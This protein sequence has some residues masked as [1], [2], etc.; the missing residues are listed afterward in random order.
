MPY[1]ASSVMYCT[2]PPPLSATAAA[3]LA[4]CRHRRP[5]PL[6]NGATKA[7]ANLVTV[8]AKEADAGAAR[9]RSKG[10]QEDEQEHGEQQEQQG[11]TA[12]ALGCGARPRV[13]CSPQP[14]SLLDVYG[15][16]SLLPALRDGV[17]EGDPESP[18]DK[19]PRQAARALG[20]RGNA[21]SLGSCLFGVAHKQCRGTAFCAYLFKKRTAATLVV[22]Y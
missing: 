18:S 12:A 19:A 3:L 10:E 11:A 8:L 2:A 16:P 20:E 22:W 7:F 4:V 14:V 15:L 21:L 17:C 6:R 1:G 9:G 13:S 5:S